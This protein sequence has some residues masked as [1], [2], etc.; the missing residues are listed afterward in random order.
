MK[1]KDL[2]LDG[3]KCLVKPRPWMA[4][5]RVAV[6][7]SS[8][9]S[10]KK[11]VVASGVELSRLE[12]KVQALR[13]DL[14]A[15]QLIVRSLLKKVKGKTANNARKKQQARIVGRTKDSSKSGSPF[16]TPNAWLNL[17]KTE[18]ECARAMYAVVPKSTLR[19]RCL[20][21]M[22]VLEKIGDGYLMHAAPRVSLCFFSRYAPR[23]HV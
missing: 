19:N 17:S 7:N 3:L 4:L 1:S 13:G 5:S 20:G 16:L 12:A 18:K 10:I 15:T 8:D 6:K 22:G 23:D 11:P 21:I 9:I 2:T 14:Y